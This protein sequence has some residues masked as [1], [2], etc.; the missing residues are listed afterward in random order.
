MKCQTKRS[1]GLSQDS[2]VQGRLVRLLC[3]FLT[4]L[5]RQSAQDVAELGLELQAFCIQFSRIR[6]GQVHV[7]K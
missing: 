2:G 4:S 7:D 5:L 3:V 1:I 6:R